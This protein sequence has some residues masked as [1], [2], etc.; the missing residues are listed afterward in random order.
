VP[1]LLNSK[2]PE[3]RVNTGKKKSSFGGQ[4][5]RSYAGAYILENTPPSPW[6]EGKNISQGHLGE[7]I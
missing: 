6:G 2:S 7:K 4:N 3:F 1:K 5:F